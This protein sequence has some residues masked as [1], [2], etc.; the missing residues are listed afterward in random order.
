[1]CLGGFDLLSIGALRALINRM[2][3]CRGPGPNGD[4]VSV[5]LRLPSTYLRVVDGSTHE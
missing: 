3:L 5:V 4:L 1:M 2:V